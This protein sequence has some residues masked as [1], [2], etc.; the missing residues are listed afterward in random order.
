MFHH[1]GNNGDDNATKRRFALAAAC[2]V[3]MDASND[4]PS[5]PHHADGAVERRS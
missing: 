2:A 1:N 3:Q 5:E 4:L